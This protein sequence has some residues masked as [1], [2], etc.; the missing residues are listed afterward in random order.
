MYNLQPTYIDS[1]LSE[2]VKSLLYYSVVSRGIKRYLAQCM[3]VQAL[4]PALTSLQTLM[5]HI[6]QKCVALASGHMR[7]NTML[8]SNHQILSH[9]C[10][11]I[12][13]LLPFI[14]KLP[15]TRGVWV[16]IG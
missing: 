4:S 12:C 8:T 7:V 9:T 1:L 2:K 16:I 3:H 11:I 10:I 15:A 6:N 5:G 13:W 14:D